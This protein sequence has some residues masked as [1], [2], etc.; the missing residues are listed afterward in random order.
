MPATSTFAP[1]E[2]HLDYDVLDGGF[3][4]IGYNFNE[5]YDAT[6]NKLVIQY[7]VID[8]PESVKIEL[9]DIDDNLLFESTE[10]LVDS[11][12]GLSI[13]KLEIDLP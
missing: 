8:S 1:D 10:P 2:V 13:A 6:A 7:S 11:T 9:K 3:A 5:I 4:G 12:P